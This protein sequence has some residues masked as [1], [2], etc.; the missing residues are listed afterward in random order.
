LQQWR[1]SCRLAGQIL[2]DPRQ[3]RKIFTGPQHT[4]RALRQAFNDT[5]GP[6]IGSRPKGVIAFDFEKFRRLIKHRGDLGI[7][8]RLAFTLGLKREVEACCEKSTDHSGPACC[9]LLS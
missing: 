1:R 9:N 3:F 8:D 7:L 6:P 4:F 5:S 2:T